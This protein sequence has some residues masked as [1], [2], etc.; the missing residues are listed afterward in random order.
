VF[1]L[2]GAAQI[3][4]LAA[5]ARRRKPEALAAGGAQQG[6]IAMDKV[7]GRVSRVLPKTTKAAQITAFGGYDQITL[8]EVPIPSPTRGQVLARVAAA[9]VGPWDGWIL[10]GKSALPQP[11]PLILGA[12][13]AGEVVAL[14][15]GVSDFS[16]GDRVY[17]VVNQRFTG[18]WAEYASASADMISRAPNRLSAVEAASAPIVAAT[19]RQALFAEAGL[20]AGQHVLILG[21]AGNV[22]SFAMQ[23]A[24]N[25]GLEAIATA[26]EDDLDYV[27][28]LG[29]QQVLGRDALR[30]RL[31]NTGAVLLRSATL[32]THK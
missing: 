12:D 14:G 27:R 9:G 13:F 21:A 8:A 19:A 20:K 17:G 5:G 4:A 25:A 18:A 15:E 11:L 22:G 26:T 30:S 32:L 23:L 31:S 2:L 29:A 24:R 6:I 7:H 1:Y 28:T 16:V 3:S 10:A